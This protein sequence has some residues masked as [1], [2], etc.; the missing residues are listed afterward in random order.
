MFPLLVVSSGNRRK[1]CQQPCPTHQLLKPFEF[2]CAV[3]L[4]FISSHSSSHFLMDTYISAVY[5]IFDTACR[6]SRDAATTLYS[7]IFRPTNNIQLFLAAI[8]LYLKVRCYKQPCALYFRACLRFLIR[9]SFSCFL[10][11]ATTMR[12]L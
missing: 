6:I 4:S 7:S 8:P 11:Y 5:A 12:D 3:S 1:Q 9:N 10:I 2:S